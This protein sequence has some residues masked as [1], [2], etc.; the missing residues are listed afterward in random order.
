MNHFTNIS[1]KELS[2]NPFTMFHNDWALVTAGSMQKHN[3]MTVSWGG[4]GILWNKEVA[5][6]YIRPQRYTY[7]FIVDNSLFTISVLPQE[8]KE[9]L[10]L[11]GRCSGRDCDKVK[12]AGL[13]PIA[14]D[15]SVS[16][17]ESRLVLVCKKLYHSDI[18]PEQFHSDDVESNYPNKD[19][20]RM[21]IGEIISAY[22]K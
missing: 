7:E 8:Y 6:I 13:T 2:Q 18:K 15:D 3:T 11:C 5:T 10:T 9:A 17:E 20:H 12:D 19:Y 4:V 1:P 16:F 14:V 21:Y 22:I